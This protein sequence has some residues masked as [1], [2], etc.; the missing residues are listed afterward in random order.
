MVHLDPPANALGIR[1]LVSV[2]TVTAITVASACENLI[3]VLWTLRDGSIPKNLFIYVTVKI[4]TRHMLLLSDSYQSTTVSSTNIYKCLLNV[5]IEMYMIFLI[6]FYVTRSVIW[7][8]TN[9][10]S[11]LI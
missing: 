9:F 7:P 5:I 1:I 2:C 6:L 4:V 3:P 8:D 10:V 11:Q